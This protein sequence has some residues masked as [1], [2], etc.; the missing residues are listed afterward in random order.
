[1]KHLLTKLASLL[2]IFAFATGCASMTDAN[3]DLPETEETSI[4]TST[5]DGSFWDSRS[6]D[7]MDPIIRRPQTGGVLE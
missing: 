2:L 7:D 4:T 6:E 1:M 3:A 5:T